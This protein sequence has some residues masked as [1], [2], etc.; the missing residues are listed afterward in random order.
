M[1]EIHVSII[2]TT[3][4]QSDL[5]LLILKAL[6][7]QTY[8]NFEVIVADDG[9]A[10]DTKQ[11]VENLSQ[12]VSFPVQH[13][14]HEDDG[15][16]ASEI[17]NKGALKSTGGY[18]IF[19]DGD[20][21]PQD[22]FIE[23]HMKLSEPGWYVRGNRIMLSE[24]LTNRIRANKLQVHLWGNITWLSLWLRREVK[25]IIPLLCFI[26]YPYRKSKAAKWYGVKTCN[27]GIWRKDYFSVNGLD[28]TYQG[29]GREDSDLAIRL[30]NSGIKRKEGIFATAVFH[31]WH[32]D[33][34]KDRLA[35]NDGL[36]EQTIKENRKRAV[37]G[38]DDHKAE[39]C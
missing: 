33:A 3:Y 11:I 22:D 4:N 12:S 34:E 25:R 26:N 13:V 24:K 18:L 29:W 17:R 16:R 28:E 31:F 19:L 6:D 21:V 35:H 39:A 2:L 14:W 7:C 15:F 38:L 37:R 20:C 23:N 32:Q 30:I 36:L 5:L 10:D 27:L 9:S 1:A 8:K